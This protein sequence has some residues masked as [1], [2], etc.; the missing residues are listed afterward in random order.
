MAYQIGSYQA[1][2]ISCLISFSS[3]SVGIGICSVCRSTFCPRC[4]SIIQQ[5][6]YQTRETIESQCGYCKYVK[7][8]ENKEDQ[9][10]QNDELASRRQDRLEKQLNTKKS[11]HIL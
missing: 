1:T 4:T 2:C 3:D 11:C 8:K 6:Y 10:Q 5:A 7:N 9:K